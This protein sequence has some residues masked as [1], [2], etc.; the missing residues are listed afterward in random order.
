MIDIQQKFL[1]LTD[2]TYV[3]GDEDQLLDRL[4]ENLIKDEVGNWYLEIGKSDTMFCCHLDTAAHKKEKVIHDIFHTKDGDVGIGTTGT[5]IL[6]ADDKAGVVL[7]MKLIENNIP[8]LYYFFVG[9][10][11]GRVGSSGILRKNEEKFKKYKRCIAFDRRDYGSVITKQMGRTCCSDEFVDALI[12]QFSKVSKLIFHNDPGGIYTD[13]ATFMDII[14]ECT[15]LSVG[16]FSEHSVEEV[17]NM[18]Y[19][20]RLSEAIVKIKW[21]NLPTVRK[22]EPMVYN[23]PKHSFTKSRRVT[24][25]LDD[26]DL[27]DI[28]YD[29]DNLMESVINMYCSN[30]DDFVP[31]EEMHY[32]SYG[33]AD[34]KTIVIIHYDGSIKVGSTTYQTVMDLEDELEMFYGYKKPVDHNINDYPNWDD[35][36]DNYISFNDKGNKEKDIDIVDYDKIISDGSNK[37]LGKSFISPNNMEGFIFDIL[38]IVYEKGRPYVLQKEMLEILNKRNK[39]IEGLIMWLEDRNNDP[40]KTYGLSWDEKR[41][42]FYMDDDMNDNIE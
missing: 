11:V 30:I 33:D 3:Y 19:L 32:V 28:F 14:P 26:E 42:R 41:R 1:D 2:Y 27:E 18:T 15:N 35:H 21:D 10:E 8:G 22:A 23:W 17:I 36:D 40:D 31:E 25:Y 16:Y 29:V 13:S 34:Q 5:T 39:K 20:I 12:E 9:E 4:P 38:S 24:D 6:G 7:L 37:Y